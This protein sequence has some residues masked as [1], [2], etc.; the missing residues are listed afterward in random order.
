ME[1]QLCKQLQYV[2]Q[3]FLFM[4]QLNVNANPSKVPVL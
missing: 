3:I 4:T 2:E 1:A